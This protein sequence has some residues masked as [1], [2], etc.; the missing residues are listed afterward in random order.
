MEW[1]PAN[2]SCLLD[3]Q[4]GKFGDCNIEK[5]VCTRALQ[6]DNLG[7]DSRIRNL[8][9]SFG[10]NRK[11]CTKT[12]LEALQVVSSVFVVL[13]ENTDLPSGAIFKEIFGVDAPLAMIIRLT[14]HCPRKIFRIIPLGGA[15]FDEKLWYLFFVHV[16]SD[17]SVRRCSR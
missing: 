12:I 16:A 17:R 13:I 11:F 5:Y 3:R 8:V 14:A 10:D 1:L 4:S 15:A 9:G 7:F 6:L 2:F